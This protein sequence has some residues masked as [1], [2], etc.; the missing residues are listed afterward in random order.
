MAL[1]SISLRDFVIVRELHLEFDA[2]FTVLTGET[3]A[4]KSILIDALQLALGARADPS[5]IREGASRCE[6][7]AEFDCP[8]GCAEWLEESGF[9]VSGSILLRR[10]VD[11][12]GRSRSWINGSV[13]TVAQLK[14][15][16]EKLVDIHGQHA[17]QSLTR[18]HAVRSLLDSYAGTDSGALGALWETWRKAVRELEKAQTAQTTLQTERERLQWQIGEMEKLSPAQQEWDELNTEHS[19]LANAQSLLDVASQ[20]LEALEGE[21]SGVVNSLSRARALLGSLAEVEPVFRTAAEVLESCEAQ[22]NDTVHSLHAYLR[23]TSPDPQR[24]GAL[25]ERLSV[26]ISLA[27]RFH[28]APADLPELLAGWKAEASRLESAAD[29]AAL[30]RAEQSAQR[31]Y[32]AAAQHISGLRHS[33]SGPLAA[34]VTAA[35]Q[36]LGMEGGRFEVK[37]SKSAQ[38]GPAGLDDVVFLVAGHPGSTPRPVAKVASGGELSRI[39]LAIAVTTSKL[40]EAQTL[41]FDEVDAGVGGAVGHAV[42]RMMRQLGQDRQVL[43]VTH[44][45]QVAASANQHLVVTKGADGDAPVSTVKPAAALERTREIARM[46]GG[47]ASTETVLAHARQLLEHGA[48]LQNGATA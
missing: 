31:A 45:P 18:L 36:D 7:G 4:G 34:T 14:T 21:E 44:L 47:D 32:L 28:C 30:E 11:A 46:L 1:I 9:D 29:L 43:A 24:L 41:I 19:R 5:T 13:A 26:W 33:A 15:L 39:S 6:I 22:A 25:D 23:T 12:Q 27:R 37:V 40:G 42:G 10:T 48:R 3:G 20:T 35:M 8:P 16:G 38:A 2:G 17:W